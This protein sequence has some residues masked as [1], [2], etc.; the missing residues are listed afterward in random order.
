MIINHV[1][2]R[3]GQPL[4]MIS[5]NIIAVKNKLKMLGTLWF[6]TAEAALHFTA[7]GTLGFLA[8]MNRMIKWI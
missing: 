5:A 8:L 2:L 1:I 4:L 6:I 3:Y 7:G